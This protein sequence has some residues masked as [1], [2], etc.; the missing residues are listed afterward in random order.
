MENC[1]SSLRETVT[2]IVRLPNEE[3]FILRGNVT[4]YY[5][6]MYDFDYEKAGGRKLGGFT[7]VF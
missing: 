5:S 2:E 7:Y 6:E 1:V 4:D 3:G